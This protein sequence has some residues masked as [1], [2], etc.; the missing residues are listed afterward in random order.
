MD[1]LKSLGVPP[2]PLYA[3]LKRGATIESP[4][5]VKV[6]LGSRYNIIIEFDHVYCIAH[7]GYDIDNTRVCNT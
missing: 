3:Q 1:R 2:G 5:G 6:G 7:Q 4:Q